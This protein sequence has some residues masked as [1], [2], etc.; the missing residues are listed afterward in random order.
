MEINAAPGIRMHH[1]P[2]EGKVRNVGEK[3]VKHLYKDNVTNI[4]V[5]SVTGT[6]GKTT[7][8]RLISYVL[9]L[10]GNTVGMTSTDGIY[11]GDECIDI[12]DDTGYESAKAILLNKDVDAAVLETARGGIIKKGLAYDLADVGVI[13]N[14]TGDHLGLDDINDL[15][16]LSFVKS[17]IVEAVK[18]EGYAVINVDD[19]WSRKIIDRIKGNANLFSKDKDNELIKENINNGNI[20]VFIEDDMICVVNNNK[21]YNVIKLSD[22]PI[23]LDGKLSFNIENA[24][25]AC[26]ALVGIRGADPWATSRRTNAPSTMSSRARSVSTRR[27]QPTPVSGRVHCG[28]SLDSPFFEAWVITT[29]MFCA[30]A[31]RSMAPPIPLTIFPGIIHEAIFPATS[32][33]KAPRTVRSTWPPRIMANDWA[34]SKIAAPV[35]AVTVC[36]PALIMS[37]SRVCSSGN[38]PIP[39]RPFS[40]WSITSMPAGM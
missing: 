10:M 27:M 7:T 22:V 11:I 20:S 28:S 30:P 25:A 32:T 31:T 35:C 38:S 37:A 36:L 33:S 34:E 15:E 29:M 26:A 6:N 39:S 24:L 23:T 13:T 4:P 3:I 9:K 12:G 40:D 2:S 8:T 19:P 14:I 1:H 18:P 16:E 21:K 17:L 5:I